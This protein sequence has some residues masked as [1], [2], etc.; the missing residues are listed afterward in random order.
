MIQG[1]TTLVNRQ[2]P[3][4]TGPKA[5]AAGNP[6]KSTPKADDAEPPTEAE[7]QPSDIVATNRSTERPPLSQLP[8]EMRQRLLKVI[9]DAVPADFEKPI[10]HMPAQLQDEQTEQE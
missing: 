7:T 3:A 8:W 1:L 6:E 9:Q 4:P 5:Q 10:E 2:V